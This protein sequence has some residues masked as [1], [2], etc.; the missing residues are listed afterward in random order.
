MTTSTVK[1]LNDIH[2]FL[3]VSPYMIS[4]S[5]LTLREYVGPSFN[6]DVAKALLKLRSDFK[7][8]DMNDAIQQCKEILDKFQDNSKEDS[9][10]TNYLK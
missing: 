1:I 2:G 3:D 8:E 4:S 10:E 5:C 9:S 7:I 6:L